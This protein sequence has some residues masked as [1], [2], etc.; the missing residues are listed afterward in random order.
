MAQSFDPLAGEI[1]QSQARKSRAVCS[2]ELNGSIK[3]GGGKTSGDQ[4]H[5]GYT[6]IEIRERYVSSCR[7][8]NN[9]SLRRHNGSG[10]PHILVL[11][12]PINNP[13]P[14]PIKIPLAR[15]GHPLF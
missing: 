14:T 2:I 3:C 1:T 4:W 15:L 10:F 8:L 12:R 5:G 9:C 13:A 11:E 6:Q 7:K